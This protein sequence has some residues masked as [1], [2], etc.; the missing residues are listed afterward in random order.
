MTFCMDISLPILKATYLEAPLTGKGEKTA[1]L[2]ERGK[3]A[4]ADQETFRNLPYGYHPY[5][6]M[7]RL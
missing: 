2:L 4:E 6:L 7:L 3:G 1:H 5:R